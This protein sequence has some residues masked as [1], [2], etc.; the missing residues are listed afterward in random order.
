M[1]FLD[2]LQFPAYGP[3][4]R[5]SNLLAGRCC[6]SLNALL[7]LELIISLIAT[8][9]G[10]TW[11]PSGADR[12]QVG[13][14][15]AIWTLLSGYLWQ[16]SMLPATISQS[17]YNTFTSCVLFIEIIVWLFAIYIDCLGFLV[18]HV[19]APILSTPQAISH[20]PN[21]GI[22]LS[23]GIMLGDTLKSTCE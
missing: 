11:G 20:V 14:M 2:L 17:V 16:H 8:F 5:L 4:D 9:M 10:P 6:H 21:Q 18:L 13:P 23:M 1:K 19:S 12:T 7:F 15:L 22:N 3:S